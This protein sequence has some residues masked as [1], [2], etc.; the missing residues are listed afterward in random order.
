[1]QLTVQEITYLAREFPQQSVLGLFHN[2]NQTP[3]GSEADHLARKGILVEG[4]LSPEAKASL[5]IAANPTRASRLIVRNPFITMEKYTYWSDGN[6]I[7]AENSAGD[8]ELS[9]GE[10]LTRAVLDLAELV[11]LSKLKSSDLEIQ[12][13]SATFYVL[14]A[15]VDLFR[16]QALQVCSGLPAS[17]GIVSIEQVQQQLE[18]PVENSLVSIL[19]AFS[20]YSIT[21]PDKVLESLQVLKARNIALTEGGGWTL[22]DDYLHFARNFLVPDKMVQVETFHIVADEQ[23]VLA[24]VLGLSA[25][26]NDVALLVFDGDLIELS[27]PSAFQLLRIVQNFMECPDLSEGLPASPVEES[28]KPQPEDQADSRM[29]VQYCPNCGSETNSTAAFCA[30]CGTKLK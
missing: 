15:L 14:L 17:S 26:I 4:R 6:L 8:L 2:L 22:S 21:P 27:T 12:L 25:G 16:N 1:M 20:S 30:K 5:S 13:D 28:S 18:S 23:M 10:E 3:A 24:G 9:S 19:A 7:L 29:K 11:G